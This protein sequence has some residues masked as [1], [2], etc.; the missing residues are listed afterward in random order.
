MDSKKA[1]TEEEIGTDSGITESDMPDHTPKRRGLSLLIAAAPVLFAL[2]LSVIAYFAGAFL[3]MWTDKIGTKA[4][5]DVDEGWVYFI[6]Y[7]LYCILFGCWYLWIVQ[8]K[9]KN[10][11]IGPARKKRTQNASAKPWN[12]AAYWAKRLPLMFVLGYSLQL[13]VSSLI[14]ILTNLFPDQ[15]S[16]Y[17]ELIQSLTGSE[18]SVKTFLAVTLLAPIAE[19]MMFRGISYHY[20]RRALPAKWA[21]VFQ[22]VVFGIYHVN[23][24]QFVYATL[25]GLL[26]GTLRKRSGSI[27]PG[28]VLHMII[29]LTAYIVPASWISA[30][31]KAA[32]IA[33]ITLVTSILS[34]ILILGKK[35]KRKNAD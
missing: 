17:R 29:N 24:V 28:I 22:A 23:V 12:P 14:S 27:V 20:A 34:S 7:L 1:K 18:V 31:P 35:K 2:F 21:I 5:G 8:Q 30:T 26:L 13:C 25:I 33:G 10:R 6:Q 19:E 11:I 4:S 32:M 15:L 3:S 9:E 16:A